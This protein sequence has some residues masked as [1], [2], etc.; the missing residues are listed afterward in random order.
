MIDLSHRVCEKKLSSAS[1]AYPASLLYLLH[2]FFPPA[3]T[4]S[5]KGKK[6]KETK[7]KIKD[8]KRDKGKDKGKPAGENPPKKRPA[9]NLPLSL[10]GYIRHLQC[11]ATTALHE[12]KNNPP[13]LGAEGCRLTAIFYVLSGLNL[14]NLS[15]RIANS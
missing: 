3:R 1:H 2:F 10:Q 12:E 9:L 8:K 5:H 15:K 4:L 7:R 11:A 13:K 14:T 6:K